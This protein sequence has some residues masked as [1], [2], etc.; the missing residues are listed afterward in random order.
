MQ[1]L[2]WFCLDRMFE[3]CISDAAMTIASNPPLFHADSLNEDED[4][5]IKNLVG[6]CDVVELAQRWAESSSIRH[7]LE[8]ARSYLKP[9]EK[10][11][12]DRVLGNSN[13]FPHSSPFTIEQDRGKGVQNWHS[14][15]DDDTDDDSDERGRTAHKLF[16]SLAG[17]DEKLTSWWSSPPSTDREEHQFSQLD[18][19]PGYSSASKTAFE[20]SMPGPQILTP[21]SSPIRPR[22][23]LSSNLV[24][25]LVDPLL[26]HQYQIPSRHIGK[27]LAPSSCPQ[28]SPPAQK[29]FSMP[30]EKWRPQ[31]PATNVCR[32]MLREQKKC[33]PEDID[34]LLTS[35]F[36]TPNSGC[37]QRCTRHNAPPAVDFQLSNTFSLDAANQRVVASDLPV[38]TKA[39]RASSLRRYPRTR[40]PLVKPQVERAHYFLQRIKIGER[41]ANS[42]PNAV[43][44]SYISKRTRLLAR[45]EK[46][47]VKKFRARTTVDP[48]DVTIVE[49]VATPENVAMPVG[50]ILDLRTQPMFLSFEAVND[51]HDVGMNWDRSRDLADGVRSAIANGKPISLPGLKCADSQS[52]QYAFR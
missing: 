29:N 31:T 30:L 33:I 42:R 16:A 22:D 20:K 45:Y 4:I 40:S 13:S 26:G 35:L 14:S 18:S 39:Y 2:D 11:L 27:T 24:Q 44:P 52:S 15:S 32:S 5:T 23:K 38:L 41:L 8:I 17:V 37:C 12:V 34:S 47:E 46:F 7:K 6:C 9:S 51:S 10:I 21:V 25:Q 50:S 19:N 36:P 48:G 1:G 49:N 43:V 3:G 28:S